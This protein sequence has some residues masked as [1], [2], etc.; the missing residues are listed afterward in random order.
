MKQV[1]RSNQAIVTIEQHVAN[2]GEIRG[3]NT[4]TYKLNDKAAKSKL[5]KAASRPPIDMEENS[6]STNLIF[7]AGA[8]IHAVLPA[9]KYWS[10]VQDSKTCKIGDYT[11]QIGGIKES[12]E[13]KGKHI[14]TQLVFFGD[15]DKVVC[16]MYNTTLLILVNGHGYKKLI[17]P[18]LKPFLT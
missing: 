14:N 7:S 6:T 3:N 18:F 17:E 13:I 1:T 2:S 9:I 8:W 15:R 5:L 4:F 11:V 12:K 10:E 16:H